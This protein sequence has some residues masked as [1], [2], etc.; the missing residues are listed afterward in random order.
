MPHIG[1]TL[2]AGHEPVQYATRE[3]ARAAALEEARRIHYETVGTSEYAYKYLVRY[4]SRR[5][6]RSISSYTRVMSRRHSVQRMIHSP[7]STM[8]RWYITGTWHPKPNAEVIGQ[9]VTSE[10]YS[11]DPT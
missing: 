2:T 10:L 4:G 3:E 7:R 5:P 11:L 8:C 6:T 1:V 9:L